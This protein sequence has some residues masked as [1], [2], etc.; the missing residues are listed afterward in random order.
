MPNLITSLTATTELEAVNKMLRAIGSAPITDLTAGQAQTD[1]AM[2]TAELRDTAREVQSMPW[3]FNTRFQVPILPTATQ[4]WTDPDGTN[5][6]LLNIFKPP[7][8]LGSFTPSQ[9]LGQVG[10]S[11][12][13]LD[14]AISPSTVYVESLAPVLVFYDRTFNRDGLVAAD[15]PKLYI[16]ATYLF[17]FTQLPETARAY[18]T[19]LAGRRFIENV[20]GSTEVAGFKQKD[21]LFAIRNLKRDQ[22]DEDTYNMLDHP[23]VSRVL[24]GR[25]RGAGL[26][27]DW[28][29]GG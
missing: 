18:I 16:D 7:A 4:A 5:P 3:Q 28:R 21:E 20:V 6:G 24:G 27:V 2:A 13:P 29:R 12:L 9:T 25:P 15:F 26:R 17:D 1:V 22:G 14:L 11:G 8:N 10:R 19:V 23:D